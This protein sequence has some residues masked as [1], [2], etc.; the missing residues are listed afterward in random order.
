[1]S[2]SVDEI[3]A[4]QVWALTDKTGAPLR[5]KGVIVGLMDSGLDWKHGDFKNAAGQSR[6]LSIWDQRSLG[7]GPA[8]ASY[9]YGTE[10]TR[11]QIASA[12]CAE[13]DTIGHGT[14]VASI[15]AGSGL[16][17]NPP[18]QVG[19]APEADIIAV[20]SDLTTARVIDGWNYI[21]GSAKLMGRPAVI[22]SSWGSGYGAKDG[23]DPMEAAIDL[24]AGPGLIFVNA[25]G[26]AGGG[27]VHAQGA[28]AQGGTA[29]M[30]IGYPAAST[31]NATHVVVWYGGKDAL[32][33]TLRTAAGETVGPVRKGGT[34]T[35]TSSDG[36][37]I[38]I[39]ATLAP[40]APNGD[41]AVFVG[42]R[43]ASAKMS[44]Q[45]NLTLT[46]D[47]VTAGGRYDAWLPLANGLGGGGS[48]LFTSPNGTREGTLGEPATSKRTITVANYV[49]KICIQSITR[50]AI[51]NTQFTAT[52]GIAPSSSRGPTRDGRQKPD[53]AAPGTLITA[54]LSA[55]SPPAVPTDAERFL[56]DPDGVH[57]AEQ[58]TSM[59]APH[60]T[61]V[62]ALML[63]KNPLLTPEAVKTALQGAARTD[64]Q[65][66]AAWNSAW[67][68]GKLD[69]LGSVTA[70][71]RIAPVP[72]GPPLLAAPA[73]GGV[74]PGLGATLAWTNPPGATQYQIQVIPANNDGP[75]LNLIR[76]AESSFVLQP[77]VL[78][79]GPYVML[80]G[81]TYTWRVRAATATISLSETDAGWSPWSEG[82]FKTPVRTS[83][84][85]SAVSP[86]AGATITAGAQPLRWANTDADV[87]YYEVQVSPDATFE[88]DPAKAT[89]SVWTN[90]VHAGLTTPPSVWTTPALQPGVIYYWRV[91]PRVQGDGAPVAWSQTFSF[92]T[93]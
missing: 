69:A 70:I 18:K 86:L 52:G 23:S 60:V 34:I 80:P 21:A 72:P 26:N 38:I 61:G 46:G 16:S 87:F 77:P 84:G 32:S 27:P 19:V 37:N 90:L 49:S 81:M 2:T 33:L 56:V 9:R 75:G 45:W 67:G 14:H 73:A 62:V 74:L 76:N 35:F 43:R 89:A 20:R 29:V 64:A 55:D 41:N 65:T 82:V 59:A 36:T 83:A 92:S 24:L 22:N 85:I 63:Q 48:E 68:N 47:T 44:G 58:G 93:Q 7:T 91:R 66:G 10:C 1:L 11:D 17:T 28:V 5:G 57:V 40:Y 53:I 71:D 30:T 8:G 78:G 42:L 15:A 54:A 51:C 3:R 79:A 39:D 50:G 25:A 6:I 88:T 12:A 31:S 4:S 13:T